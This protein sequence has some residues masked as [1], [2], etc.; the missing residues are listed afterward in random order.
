MS[1]QIEAV[2]SSFRSAAAGCP[3]HAVRQAVRLCPA[4]AIE[5]EE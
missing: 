1:E 3:F 4:L 5:V 2:S